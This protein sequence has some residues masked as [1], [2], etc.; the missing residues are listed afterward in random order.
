MPEKLNAWRV[1]VFRPSLS[2]GWEALDVE[3]SLT[4]SLPASKK[5]ASAMKNKKG[6]SSKQP[7]LSQQRKTNTKLVGAKP[8]AGCIVIPRLRFRI[9]F[10]ADTV[11]TRRQH[12]LR[13]ISRKGVRVL[14]F[15]FRSIKE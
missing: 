15:L 7:P 1:Q 6:T 2:T 14:V 3:K 4:S 11:V 13:I 8:Q 5:A 12:A 10:T 9:A